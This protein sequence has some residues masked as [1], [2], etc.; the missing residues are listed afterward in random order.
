L[1]SCSGIRRTRKGARRSSCAVVDALADGGLDHLDDG[2]DERPRRVVLAAVATGVAHVA[3]L[4]FV[5]M[6]ELVLFRLRSEV[7][8]VDV[9]DDLAQ[10]VTAL[11]LVLD[12]AEDLPDLY[13][14]VS[15]PV[16][17]ALNPCR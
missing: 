6:G 11:D 7:Q 8:P 16:A 17:F 2:A 5:E 15:G 9:V 4:G 14:S 1:T 3:D 10:V 13:S 12:L